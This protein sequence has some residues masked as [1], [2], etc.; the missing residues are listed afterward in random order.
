[1]WK[2][3]SHRRGEIIHL[4]DWW[5]ADVSAWLTAQLVFRFYLSWSQIRLRPA[6]V[7]TELRSSIDGQKS[8]A[9]HPLIRAVEISANMSAPGVS[10]CPY[11]VF[12]CHSSEQ[13][14]TAA[15]VPSGT[16][17]EGRVS[18]REALFSSLSTFNYSE[19]EPDSLY[20]R[21]LWLTDQIRS[22][23]DIHVHDQ[24]WNNWLHVMDYGT[25]SVSEVLESMYSLDQLCFN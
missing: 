23:S 14:V 3:R 24:H 17:T 8:R 22:A 15:S 12:A 5:R 6:F 20:Q 21:G 7:L 2:G 25:K 9:S 18:N 10:T 13:W 1:M 19:G 16:E 4:S 11:K